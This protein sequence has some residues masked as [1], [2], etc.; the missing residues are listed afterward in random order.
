M[1]DSVRSELDTAVAAI[2]MRS[3]AAPAIGIVLGSG[4]GAF[5]DGLDDPVEIPYGEIPGWPASTAVGHAG[6]LVLGSFGGAHVAVMRGRA[7]LYEGLEPSRVV[8]GIRVLAL[9]GIRTLVLTNAS[10][11]STR[12]SRPGSSSRSR[13]ISTSRG[14]HRSSARTTRRSG[15]AFR[16]CPTHTT[17]L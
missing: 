15:R 3:N 9:L 1:L 4:L 13:T 8:F 14:N 10:A 2:Q 17:R 11:R 5:A 6:T 16:T 12:T 7:H